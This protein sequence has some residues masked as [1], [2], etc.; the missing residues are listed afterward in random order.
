M[1]LPDDLQH[2]RLGQRVQSGRRL[3]QDQHVRVE[4]Q[5]EHN[6]DALAHAAG[7]LMLIGGEHPLG[8]QAHFVDEQPGAVQQLAH[9]AHAVRA[10]DVQHLL[11]DR[12]ERVQRVLRRLEHVADLGAAH[13][14]QLRPAQRQH[15]TDV[16][17]DDRARGDVP[18]CGD[19]AQQR[20]RQRGLARPGLADQAGDLAAG[21]VQRHPRDR[22]QRPV[23]RRERHREVPHTDRCGRARPVRPVRPVFL[24]PRRAGQRRLASV[25]S[26]QIRLSLGLK[27]SSTAFASVTSARV[28]SRM[29][30]SG[31]SR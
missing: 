17:D 1:H 23:R 10:A 27:N 3:V 4:H 8:V 22:G 28:I 15:V 25:P 9:V 7:Q 5:R 14:P 18:G 31:D 20:Q 11:A 21:E 29:Q 19:G 2:R 12:L 30:M 16:V 6:A 26:H 13:L 24:R